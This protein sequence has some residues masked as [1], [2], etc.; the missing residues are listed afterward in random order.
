MIPS[1]LLQKENILNEEKAT[2]NKLSFIDKTIK[3]AGA[4][5]S[6]TFMQ[7]Q[8]T[9][10]KGLLQQLDSRVNVTF[11]FLFVVLISFTHAIYIQLIHAVI[12]FILFCFSRLPLMHVYKRILSFSFV[13]GFVVF[14][15]V[16]LN[17]ITLGDPLF[18]LYRFS[19]SHSWWI[20]SLPNEISITYQGLQTL[21][22]LTLK[23]MNS[24]TVVMLVLY[25]TTFERVVKSLSFFKVPDIFLLT[26]TLTYK[27]IFILSTTIIE[28]YHAIKM[29]WW[30]R[31]KVTDA[32]NI[33]AGRIGYLFRKSW[34][35]YELVYMAMNA[36]GFNGQMNLCY[37]EKLKRADYLFLIACIIYVL[38]SLLFQYNVV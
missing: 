19:H 37:F 31:G 24:I 15:P 3:K 33:I 25:S 17:M 28:T 38:L 9:N 2:N 7:W 29:R 13:F 21:I 8:W 1:F 32:K 10:K 36:R 35:R 12:L 23:V 26:L 34:E 22:K 20:Y 4:F 16:C 18:T 14:F 27:L 11:L 5:V 30:N 6:S